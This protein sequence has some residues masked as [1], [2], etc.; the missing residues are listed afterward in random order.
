MS[1]SS[2]HNIGDGSTPPSSL[3]N[4]GD[5]SMPPSSLDDGAVVEFS[6]SAFNLSAE[7]AAAVYTRGGAA[8]IMDYGHDMHCSSLATGKPSVRGIRDHAFTDSPLLD[9]GL[10]DISAD[11]DFGVVQRAAADAARHMVAVASSDSAVAVAAAETSSPPPSAGESAPPGQSGTACDTASYSIAVSSSGGSAA[12]SAVAPS[13]A[14]VSNSNSGDSPQAVAPSAAVA[15]VG[16]APTVSTTTTSFGVF[17][18]ISQSALLQSLGLEA[19]VNRLLRSLPPGDTASRQ[20]LVDDAMRLAHP[21]QMGSIYKALAL[22][23]VKRATAGAG[24]GQDEPAPPPAFEGAR[25]I[26]ACG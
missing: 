16:T 8:L 14:A 19:R 18:P 25:A 1:P 9:P 11:V 2:L 12:C 17:G 22:L 3:H 20:R 5:S 7:I 21:E 6:P 13:A 26:R 23:C 10:V 15:A 4:V 24:A